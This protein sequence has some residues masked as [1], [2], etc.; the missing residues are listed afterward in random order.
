[1]DYP[2]ISSQGSDSSNSSQLQV[3]QVDYEA[4]FP[5]AIPEKVGMSIIFDSGSFP[6]TKYEFSLLAMF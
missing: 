4:N 6:Y 1:M 3:L 2:Q 5:P